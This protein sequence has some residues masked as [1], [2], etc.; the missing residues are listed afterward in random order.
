MSTNMRLYILIGALLACL[1]ARADLTVSVSTTATQAILEYSYPWG[2][3]CSLQVADM[4]RSIAITAG[5]QTAGTVTLATLAPHGLSSGAVVYLEG[6]GLWD[7]WQTISAVSDTT[8]LTFVSTVSGSVTAGSVGVLI[9]DLNPA[10]FASVDQ[11]AREGNIATLN[12]KHRVFVVGKRTSDVALDG[13]RY[14]RALQASSRHH[15]TLSCSAGTWSGDFTTLNPPLGDTHNEGLPVDRATGQYAYPTIQWTNRGQALIDPLTGVRSTRATGPGG[16]PSAIQ[17]FQTAIDKDSAWTTH[18]GPLTVGGSATATGPCANGACELFLRADSLTL[19]G[20]ATYTT[21]YSSGSSIDW[22][23]V[24]VA[25]ASISN[26]S[27]A[28]DDCKIAACL[29]VNGVTCNTPEKTVTLTSTPTTYTVGTQAVM[30]LWQGSGPPTITRPDVSRAVGVATYTHSTRKLAWVSGNKFSV[31]WTAGSRITV[32]GTEYAIDSVQSEIALTLSAPG[33]GVDLTSQAYSGNNFGVLIRKKTATADTVTIG[34]ATFQYGISG[35]PSWPS[36]S[37]GACAPSVVTVNGVAGYNCFSS[38]ELLWI[39]ADGSDVRDLGWISL[40][41]RRDAGNNQYMW[42]TGGACGQ[43]GL[44]NFDPADGDT[45]YCMANIYPFYEPRLSFLKI[46]YEGG[47]TSVTPGTILPDCAVSGQPCIRVTIMQPNKPDSL[48]IGGPA[49]SAEYQASGYVATYWWW[50]GVSPDGHI[51]VYTRELGGQDTRGWIFIFDLGDRTP[52]GTG[53]NSLHVV[54]ATSSYQHAPNSWC[55]IHADGAPDDAGWMGFSHNDFSI[56]GASYVHRMTLTSTPLNTTVGVDGGLNTCPTNRFGIT[57]QNCTD[58]VTTGEPVNVGD[59]THLQAT[60]IGDVIHVDNE[61]MRILVKTDSQHYTVQRGYVG[62]LG[63]HASTYL[64]MSCGLVNGVVWQPVMA[65]WNY[66]ADPYGLNV[67]WDTILVDW[68]DVGGHGSAGG[69]A[70]VQSVG[71][72]SRIGEAAC[73]SDLLGGVWASCYQVRRGTMTSIFTQPSAGVAID[74]P[75]AGALGIGNPN[76]VDSHPGP[77]QGAWCLD[78]R[79]MTGGSSD[80]VTSMIGSSSAPFT[81]V[82]GQLWKLAGGAVGLSRKLMTTMA[83]VGRSPLVDISGPASAIASDSSTA[84][85]YCVALKTGECRAGSAAND[86]YVN[87]P[88]VSYGYCYYPGIANQMDDIN[89]IC[90]GPLGAYTGNLMQFGTRQ[91]AFG[92]YIRRLGPTFSRWNQQ[93]VFWNMSMLPGGMVGMS[94][95][96]WLDG[97]RHDNIVTVLPPYPISD[98]VARNTFVPV[99]VKVPPPVAA[100]R[101]VTVDFG[102]DSNFFCTSR[103]ETCVAASSA[104]D[105]TSPFHFAQSETYSGM[106]CDSGCT[107]TIPA[108]SQRVLYYRWKQWDSGSVVATSNT[109]A[110]VTP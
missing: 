52:T 48:Q 28:G 32:A 54:A 86:V 47:H 8:H 27:C 66:R 56:R 71:S 59:G 88:Y 3:T 93:S 2:G 96:R 103:Q 42:A 15:Y 1:S 68:Y 14:S 80:T 63:A 67:N 39:S 25:G 50:G 7:G 73:P 9:D 43:N 29:T 62:L 76:T 20:G 53:P 45:W 24:S 58:I 83:Y 55:T 89:A 18:T 84:Y 105:Q 99:V 16:S 19:T 108:L 87:A 41:G 21:G 100:G 102:Y 23:T 70:F 106:P 79:P 82:T 38:Q 77:C 92:S 46:H 13:N 49:F 97:V 69:G 64:P 5:S 31:K 75:F 22:V 6:T 35:N 4:N 109:L 30:D 101:T 17:T 61:W 11:D 57:G 34:Y 110:L 94:Q 37:T 44:S 90:I 85:Q 95:V 98:S 10:L 107:V 51:M 91:D 81:K 65:A 72:P 78:A 33:P 74:P 40:T 104:V 60:Q 36:E 12:G 26:G